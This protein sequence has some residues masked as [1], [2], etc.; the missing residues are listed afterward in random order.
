MTDGSLMP[1]TT[2]PPATVGRRPAPVTL[3]VAIVLC[4]ALCVFMAMPFLGAIVWSV[5]LAVLSAPF[6]R[7]VSDRIGS[8]GVSA[9][10]TVIVTACIVVVPVMMVAGTLLNEAVRSATMVVPMFAKQ[11][12]LSPIAGHRWL[13]S[14]LQWVHDKV[15][16]PDLIQTASTALANWSGSVLRASFSGVASL[17][18]TF[19]FLFYMLR[20]R[21]T[22]LAAAGNNLPLSDAEFQKLRDRVADTIFATVL[23]TLAVAAL[24]GGLGGLMFWWLGLPAPVFWGVLM[25]MLAIVP[26]LGAFVIWGPA[27]LYLALTG[28]YTSA[29]ILTVWGTLIVGLVDNV[30]YPMLVGSRLRMHTMLSFIA[31]VGGL[32]VMGPTG[33]VLGPLLV[34]V[35]L[36]LVQIWR[37]RATPSVEAGA[38]QPHAVP[39]P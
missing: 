10:V 9:L 7:I 6:D 36:T 38:G 32:V 27:A 4:L 8:R 1:N 3:V 20:D 29:V 31:V 34:A 28:A 24:Q 25:A 21:T 17:L 30:V 18:L 35:T 13:A 37:A 23:G 33:V 39:L 16:F 12:W 11:D 22:I 26:F 19:Y 2:P 5:T 14:A 15:D